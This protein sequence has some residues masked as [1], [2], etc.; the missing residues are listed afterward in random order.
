[1][2]AIRVIKDLPYANYDGRVLRLDLFIPDDVPAPRPTI[3]WVRGGG[4]SEVDKNVDHPGEFLAQH[5]FVAAN[6]EY[7]SSREVIAP[8]NVHD[9]K[10]AVRW[11]RAN[12]GAYGI[13]PNRIGVYGGSAGGHLVALLAVTMGVKEL[14]GNGGNANVSSA[15]QAACDYCGPADLTRIAIPAIR[16][17]FSVL[18]E[19]TAEYLGGPVEERVEL[20]RFISPL[21]WVSPA[22]A[23]LW[24]VHGDADSIV[25]VE[26]SLLFYDALKKAGAPASLQIVKGGDHS[27]DQQLTDDKLIAFFR[28]ALVVG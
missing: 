5:G 9:C 4:W 28:Q 13:D 1:M 27:W 20:A 23:P 10:A 7:R 15:V 24:I 14:E 25:P 3:M 18:Y 2:K 17:Q 12:A 19:A 8:G 26:E 22:A 21:T 6:I 16:Q 11:L